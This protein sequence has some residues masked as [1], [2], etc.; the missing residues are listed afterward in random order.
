[1]ALA[2]D[3]LDLEVLVVQTAAAP[4][5][6]KFGVA[7]LTQ[8]EF[9]L[10]QLIRQ[11]KI[12][13]PGASCLKSLS[14]SFRGVGVLSYF[15]RT[16][17]RRNYLLH[18]AW[19]CRA[20]GVL[21]RSRGRPPNPPPSPPSPLH[22]AFLC[23]WAYCIVSDWGRPPPNPP[24]PPLRCAWLSCERGSVVFCRSRERTPNPPLR[25]ARPLC[26]A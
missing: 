2:R 21:Y 16:R 18:C 13:P 6:R 8:T 14:F 5:V 19:R 15:F 10:A 20:R 24:P 12:V 9:Y 23:T 4:Q 25:C 11:N 3:I 1:M 17:S 7:K 22:L 26:C